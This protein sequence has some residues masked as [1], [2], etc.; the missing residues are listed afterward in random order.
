METRLS[1]I[2]QCQFLR[3][4][5]NLVLKHGKFKIEHDQTRCGVY[6]SVPIPWCVYVV[7]DVHP[8]AKGSGSSRR[9][10]TRISRNGKAAR[11]T[12]NDAIHFLTTHGFSSAAAAAASLA[13]SSCS[14]AGFST[15][16]TGDCCCDGRLL[17]P[18]SLPTSPS[19]A[20]VM[21]RVVRFSRGHGSHF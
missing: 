17:M 7:A 15:A 18:W 8:D 11:Q 20:I 14:C 12:A 4:K 9:R 6:R 10:L 1:F 3:Q 5:K 13:F 19:D 2:V 21:V 16:A